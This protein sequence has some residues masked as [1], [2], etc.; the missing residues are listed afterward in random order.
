MQILPITKKDREAIIAQEGPIVVSRGHVHELAHLPGDGCRID[1][2]LVGWIFYA[3]AG[4]ECEI[5]SLE[6]RVEN[7]GIGTRLIE[8]VKER[9]EAAGCRKIWLITS[10]DNIRAI[11]FYQKRGFDL[12]AVHRDA[13]TEARK[14]KPSIPLF[15]CEGIPIRHELEFELRLV[16]R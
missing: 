5:V 3:I 14:R 13:I 1:E 8:S 2:E 7:R 15:G 11:R 12:V 16:P 4:D 9:A 10:N 6:S